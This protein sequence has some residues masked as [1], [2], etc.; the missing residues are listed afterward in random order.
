MTLRR[1]QSTVPPPPPWGGDGPGPHIRYSRCALPVK[2]EMTPQGH[3][4]P[5]QP[6][7]TSPSVLESRSLNLSPSLHYLLL[8]RC[9]SFLF[10]LLDSACVPCRV[11]PSSRPRTGV[12][13]LLSDLCFLPP[14]LPHTPPPSPKGVFSECLLRV[15][16]VSVMF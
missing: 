10:L 5:G 7:V 9:R 15:S 1:H 14:F 16:Y 2:P 3:R 13:L 11:A 6:S 4:G 12:P 8:S